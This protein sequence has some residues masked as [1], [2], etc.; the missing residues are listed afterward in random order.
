MPG[1][2]SHIYGS[3]LLECVY[4]TQRLFL[5]AVQNSIRSTGQVNYRSIV[6][7]K[8]IMATD[9]MHREQGQQLK[10]KSG[11]NG[12]CIMRSIAATIT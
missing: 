8:I 6:I 3:F 7:N 12:W 1:S 11:I 4:L 9:G 10:L 2:L 5:V